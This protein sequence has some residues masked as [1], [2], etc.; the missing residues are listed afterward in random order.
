MA[1]VNVRLDTDDVRRVAELRKAGVQLSQLV[2][3]AIRAEHEQRVARGTP[4]LPPS[5][6]VK[7]IL[8]SLPDPAGTPRSKRRTDRRAIKRRIVAKLKRQR[9]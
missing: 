9:P 2:R 6:I 1:L 7:Q 4:K 3:S 5:T 8:A